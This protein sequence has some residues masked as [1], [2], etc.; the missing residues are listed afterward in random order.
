MRERKTK[1]S[2]WVF[3]NDLALLRDLMRQLQRRNPEMVVTNAEGF[4]E[5]VLA[6]VEKMDPKP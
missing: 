5:A 3:P 6:L 2:L 1:V 4:H